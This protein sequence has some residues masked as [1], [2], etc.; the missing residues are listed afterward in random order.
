MFKKCDIS[1]NKI[2]MGVNRVATITPL[3]A[4]VAKEDAFHGLG[5]EFVLARSENVD[6][7]GTPENTRR[8]R[9]EGLIGV[10]DRMR[11]LIL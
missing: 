2:S 5:R 6:K 11:S 1:R 9:E 7:T 8:K 10:K 4:G 3:E